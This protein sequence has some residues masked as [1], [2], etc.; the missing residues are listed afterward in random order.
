MENLSIKEL[1]LATQGKLVLGNENDFVSDVVIDSRK[2]NE[3]NVFV[4]LK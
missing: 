4:G 1:L 3:N 2:A